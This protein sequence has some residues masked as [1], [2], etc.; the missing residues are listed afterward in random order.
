MGR[1]TGAAKIIVPISVNFGQTIDD[2][3]EEAALEIA[4]GVASEKDDSAE[5]VLGGE[6]IILYGVP[7]CGKSHTIKD[8][9]CDDEK[10]M[11]RVVFHPEYTNADFIG[12]I[13]P[14]VIEGHISYE[15][16]PGPF[17][18]I[19]KKATEDP[20]NLYHPIA[21]RST[22]HDADPWLSTRYISVSI[23]RGDFPSP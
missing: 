17:T 9:Y 21:G 16:N 22:H 3:M 8:E 18:R 20:A 10:Y 14:V 15:F 7:G 23:S 11:E 2:A 1:V 6:N 4:S 12:Q 19:L 13:L 5:R